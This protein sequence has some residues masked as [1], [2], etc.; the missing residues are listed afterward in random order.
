MRFHMAWTNIESV[1]ERIQDSFFD[2]I[3]YSMDRTL[4]ELAYDLQRDFKNIDK[5]LQTYYSTNANNKTIKWFKQKCMA[6]IPYKIE[7]VSSS[8]FQSGENFANKVNNI[9]ILGT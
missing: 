9:R 6:T 2:I 5:M 4:F 8:G 3:H 1:R 7:A